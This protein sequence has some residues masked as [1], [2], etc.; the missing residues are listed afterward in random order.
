MASAL[1]GGWPLY[2]TE[3]GILRKACIRRTVSVIAIIVSAILIVMG[4]KK[5]DA[6]AY[7]EYLWGETTT[8]STVHWYDEN[9]LVAHALGKIDD[10]TYTNSKEAL[11]NSYANGFRVFE[12]DMILTSDN[13]L[14]ACH[15]WE[16]WHNLIEDET[17]VEIPT[18]EEFLQ[19]R[20]YDQY[21]ALAIED[22]L[23]FLAENPDTYLVTDSKSTEPEYYK[24]EFQRMVEA[25]TELGCEDVLDRVIV[26]IYH[27]Y[28]YEDIEEIYPFQII[29]TLYQE[30]FDGTPDSLIDYVVFCQKNKINTITM[31]DYYYSDEIGQI[32]DQAGIKIFVH[33]VNDDEEKDSFLSKNVGVYTDIK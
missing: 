15:D 29:Y 21:T 17:S 5:I 1:G 22:L 24:L 26:Q 9:L 19:T 6:F 11:E 7:I 30:G 32:A 23:L 18:K 27:D 20:F 8:Q 4:I 2:L 25:A 33:T 16:K 31:W 13:E 3:K 14:V 10:Y 28:M 12:C